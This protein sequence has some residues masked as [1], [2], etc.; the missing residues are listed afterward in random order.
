MLVVCIII[1]SLKDVIIVNHLV[2]FFETM[3]SEAEE[4]EPQKPGVAASAQG[5]P[6][7]L[8][9]LALRKGNKGRQQKNCGV[10]GR[11]RS[12]EELDRVTSDE[13]TTVTVGWTRRKDG[14]LPKRAAELRE[15]GRRRRGRPR[16]RWE[17]CGEM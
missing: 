2:H 9:C 10:N 17:D 7:C 1:V 5:F 8:G 14:G 13:Q 6:C 16:L 15:Q 4:S 3:Q 11:D 12:V